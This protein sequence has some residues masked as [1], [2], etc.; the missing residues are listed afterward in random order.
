MG[1]VCNILPFL[2]DF[3]YLYGFKLEI[4]GILSNNVDFERFWRF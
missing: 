4:A 2:G 3:W 1:F